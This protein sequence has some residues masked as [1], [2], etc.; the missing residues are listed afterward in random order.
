MS[1]TG[2]VCVAG[3]A[4][5]GCGVL[6]ALASRTW[7]LAL[8]LQAVGMGAVGVSGAAILFGA[9]SLGVRFRSSFS[10]AFGVDRLSG[11]FLVV[12]AL[13]AVPAAIYARDALR[14]VR[15][16][17]AVA[18]L[19]GVFCAALVGLVAA[20]DVATFLGFW[21][22]MTLLPASV[23]LVVRQDER[24]RRDV[25]AYLAI[26]HLGGIGVWA[27]MLVLAA[28]GALGGAPLHGGGL[29][30]LVAAAAIV[31]FGT[32]AG[33]MPLHSWLPRAHPLAPANVSA[34]M[35]GVMIKLALYG[36]IRVLFIWDRPVPLWVG[37][38]LLAIGALSAVGGVLYALF[39]HELKR[40][41]AFHSIENVGIVALGLGASL[42]FRDIGQPM[43]SAIA[44]AAALL[45]A[46]N[47]ALFKGLLFLGAGAFS[48]AVGGLELDRLGGLLR[49]MPWTG[50]TFALGAMAIAGLPPLNGFASEWLTLQSLLHLGVASHLGVALA[51]AL[52]TAALAGTAAL[53]VYC[54]VKVI[55]LVLLGLPRRSECA[56]ASEVPVGMR[57][58]MVFLAGSCVA[59]GVLPG[60]LVPTLA[61][62]GPG[63]VRLH[64]GAGLNVPGTG[65]LPTLALALALVLLVS[66]LVRLARSRRAAPAPTWTCGQPPAT[67]LA[68][69][70]AGFTKPLR[71]VL[72][73]LLRPQREV[74]VISS[75]GVV[76]SVTYQAEVPHLFDTLLYGPVSRG[77][78]RAAGI[79]RSVQSGSLRA[80]LIY[81]LA[82]LGL[83]LALARTG[84]LG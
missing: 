61:A 16:P 34:L 59:L 29:R 46:L 2:V 31:G 19:S 76:E 65:S 71:L 80:Y 15:H 44:F 63:R 68:W 26:T 51:G 18:A 75:L 45:H 55:G 62:L 40:L 33:T 21:E 54:F 52:A 1:A 69:T 70:S 22:L 81:L 13:I 78:L 37:L 12:L 38:T 77:A 39:Q 23:I 5:L 10:P 30:A 3:A 57:A 43:W 24:A 64:E 28:H 73:A 11:F 36:L 66:A 35:S 74:R 83:L 49:R 72:E 79:A 27:S 84:V 42:V 56:E 58:S 17:R 47:H 9:P 20:R 60:L 14:D 25:F 82:L 8:A 7:R 32:K 50:A 53:A 6:F 48:K 41:L 4:V 67:G